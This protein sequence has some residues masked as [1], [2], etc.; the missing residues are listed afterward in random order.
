[1]A[2]PFHPSFGVSPPLLVGR[3]DVLEG[4]T[5]A[6]ADGSGAAGRAV[7]NTGARGAGKTVM[8]NAVRT[9]HGAVARL[10]MST[11]AR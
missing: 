1:M 3:D 7:L 8:L 4:F 11:A 6:L 10:S 2:S 5:E 9:G